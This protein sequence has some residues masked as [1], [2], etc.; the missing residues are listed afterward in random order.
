M[1]PD[2]SNDSPLGLADSVFAAL[3][4]EPERLTALHQAKER[5]EHLF[6]YSLERQQI[7]PLMHL[8]WRYRREVLS[9]PGEPEDEHARA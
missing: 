8:V 6:R 1:N 7:N 5:I 9:A 3:A 4:D 2:E